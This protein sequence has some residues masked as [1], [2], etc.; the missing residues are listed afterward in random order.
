MKTLADSMLAHPYSA[1]SKTRNC[2]DINTENI[3]KGQHKTFYKRKE[4]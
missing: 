2:N 1:K 4:I 3:F